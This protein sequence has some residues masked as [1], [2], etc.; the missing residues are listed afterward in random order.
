MTAPASP[1]PELKDFTVCQT[2]QTPTVHADTYPP[3]GKAE[4][5]QVTVLCWAP[6]WRAVTRPGSGSQ[7][8]AK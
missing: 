4:D 8:I 7:F 5:C 1:A 3:W 2:L 6:T